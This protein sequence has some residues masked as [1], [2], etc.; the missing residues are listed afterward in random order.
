M[1]IKKNKGFTLVEL[2][3]VISIIGMLTALLL[4]A[5]QAAREAGR[6]ATCIS[7]QRNLG[8]ALH[9]YAS[10]KGTLPGFINNFG[11]KKLSTGSVTCYGSWVAALFPYIEKNDIWEE[12]R[13][14]NL[15]DS[16][17]GTVIGSETKA[18]GIRNSAIKIL[19][20]SSNP[21]ADATSA[22]NL[23]HRANCGRHGLV[24]AN[25]NVDSPYAGVFDVNGMTIDGIRDGSSTTLML[26]EAIYPS[27]WSD[28]YAGYGATSVSGNTD[29]YTSYNLDETGNAASPSKDLE[30]QLGFFFPQST[31]SGDLKINKDLDASATSG[32]GN[33]GSY[34]P[35]VVVVT[36]ADGHSQTLS[37][38]IDNGVLLHIMTPNSKKVWKIHGYDGTGYSWAFVN[39]GSG[40]GKFYQVLDEA[41]V[42]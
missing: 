39:D 32:S 12:L 35:G 23:C 13:E 6:R 21:E 37:E 14:G 26:G 3:V 1:K 42:F 25:M 8:L 33:L 19:A 31:S 28:G 5:V 18:T 24:D 30:L 40:K 41:D 22:Q 16:V 27:S 17:N 38:S 36:F 4:P 29:G 15:Y 7:N 11:V 9:N 20:C 2:L 10:S 34:H